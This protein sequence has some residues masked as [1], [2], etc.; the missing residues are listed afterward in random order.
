MQEPPTQNQDLSQPY[1]Q[2]EL[3]V[4][5][6]QSGTLDEPLASESSQAQE[7]AD[8]VEYI[9]QESRED[10]LDSVSLSRISSQ[11]L[12]PLD[13]HL[14]IAEK[15]QVS[16]D[17]RSPDDATPD[18]QVSI[19]GDQSLETTTVDAKADHVPQALD[20]IHH[21]SSD[22]ISKGGSPSTRSTFSP[23]PGTVSDSTLSISGEHE[24]STQASSSAIID[25][26]SNQTGTLNFLPPSFHT[27]SNLDKERV[28]KTFLPIN[29]TKD[30]RFISS[31]S[32]SSSSRK[33]QNWRLH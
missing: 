27:R 21:T 14:E 13:S 1:E 33:N 6:T 31:F 15:P 28:R 18:D 17:Q 29:T 19:A 4:Q 16:P 25:S 9:P 12:S 7:Q 10:Q 5:P 2:P 26:P 23:T 20:H 24:G 3:V 32:H 11:T 8:T 22:P 30:P